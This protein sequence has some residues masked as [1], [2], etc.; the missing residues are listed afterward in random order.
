MKR[1]LMVSD[2]VRFLERP[3]WVMLYHSL[4]WN[5]T[6]VSE[7]VLT[8]FE[9]IKN[10]KM[11]ELEIEESDLEDLKAN[12]YLVE[13]IWDDRRIYD[14]L[15]QENSQGAIAWKKVKLLDLLIS[16]KCNFWCKHC[17]LFW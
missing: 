6:I 5:P 2:N 17:I 3:E 12:Y 9:Y 14:Q 1:Q 16:E 7:D 13:N 11:D 4:F 15:I 10:W 8:L